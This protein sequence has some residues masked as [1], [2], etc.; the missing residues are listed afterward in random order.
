MARLRLYVCSRH[1]C[2]DAAEDDHWSVEFLDPQGNVA[3]M[4]CVPPLLNSA[5]HFRLYFAAADVATGA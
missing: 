5:I 3:L 4:L 2:F 1:F